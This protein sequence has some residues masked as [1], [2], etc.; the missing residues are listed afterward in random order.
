MARPSASSPTTRGTHTT[1][2]APSTSWTG[3]LSTSR[4]LPKEAGGIAAGLAEVGVGDVLLNHTLGVEERAVD[5]DGVLHNAQEPVALVVK[6][7]QDDMLELVV[8]R[9][10]VGVVVQPFVAAVAQLADGPPG[11]AFDAALDP[12]AVQNA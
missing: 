2:S 4:L 3:A 10:R 1:P 11:N 8:K 6:H 12:P 5:G 7:G 9:F